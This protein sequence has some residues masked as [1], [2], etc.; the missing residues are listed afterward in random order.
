MKKGK[1]AKISGFNNAKVIYGTVDSKNFKSVYLNLESW[2][3]PK[4]DYENWDRIVSNLSR[5]IKH[6]IH[7]VLDKTYFKSDYIVDLDLRASGINYGKKSFMSLEVT[8]YLN[9]ECDFKDTILKDKL[10]RIAKEIYIESFKKSEYF[11]FTLTK[12]VKE[13][14]S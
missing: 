14:V 3:T 6:T 13:V 5:N 1:T 4:D 2:V 10:K 12:K 11:E 7:Y 9:G 8:F